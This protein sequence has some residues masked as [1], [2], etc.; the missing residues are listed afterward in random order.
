ML[1][2]PNHSFVKFVPGVYLVYLSVP[3]VASS[4]ISHALLSACPTAPD[5]V[6]EHSP[7]G[8]ALTHWRPVYAP[9]PDLPVFTYVRNP[10]DKFL[11]YYRDKFLGA[12]EQGFELPHLGQL[13]FSPS[14][15]IEDVVEHMLQIPVEKMEHHAQPQHRIVAPQGSYVAEFTGQVEGMDESWAYIQALSLCDF[16]VARTRNTTDRNSSPIELREQT[17]SKL[18]AYYDADFDV[19]EYARPVP[20]DK[21][22][23]ERLRG[24]AQ[25]DRRTTAGMRDK[26]LRANE[27]FITEAES[28]EDQGYRSRR[29]IEAQEK[30]NDF[31]LFCNYRTSRPSRRAMLSML[32]HP[33][34]RATAAKK[35]R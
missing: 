6:S 31:L 24:K 3:K 25:P 23:L 14:M 15:D 5:G 19:F 35:W 13:G 27:A 4:S 12:R 32:R 18:V 11:S 17:M 28:L 20:A 9:R 33:S 21:D 29:L 2:S 7:I 1:G 16:V 22:T 8:K 30:F 10:I 26:R 34:S